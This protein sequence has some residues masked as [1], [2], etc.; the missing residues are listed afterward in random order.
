MAKREVFRG[1]YYMN[2]AIDVNRG[3]VDAVDANQQ[4]IISADQLPSGSYGH[5]VAECSC[6]KSPKFGPNFTVQPRLVQVLDISQPIGA[7]RMDVETACSLL[8]GAGA[9]VPVPGSP[10][11][12]VVNPAGA[13]GGVA[14]PA[15]PGATPAVPVQPVGVPV[16]QTPAPAGNP[17]PQNTLAGMNLTDP[18]EGLI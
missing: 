17:P 3:R 15:V 4:P 18:A 1:N 2:L 8:P 16:N 10:A 7:V 6:Y 13:A 9:A 14:I 11:P 5:V 12:A